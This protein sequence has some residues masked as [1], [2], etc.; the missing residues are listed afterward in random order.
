MSLFIQVELINKLPV[1]SCGPLVDL[2]PGPH[3][4]NTS[5]VKAFKCLTVQIRHQ[6]MLTMNVA[7]KRL[8]IIFLSSVRPLR[9]TGGVNLTVKVFRESMASRFLI[10]N[11]SRYLFFLQISFCISAHLCSKS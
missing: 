8:L 1:Y 6:K 10:L 5:F 3:I 4:S 2:C 11:A 7:S 9:P